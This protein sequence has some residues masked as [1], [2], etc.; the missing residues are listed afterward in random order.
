MKGIAPGRAN[1]IGEHVDYNDGYILPFAIDKVTEVNVENSSDGLIHIISEGY[2]EECFAP[3]ELKK[4]DKWTD[5]IKGVICVL[6][7]NT[8][9]KIEALTYRVISNVPIGAGLSSSA[10]VEVATAEALNGFYRL[11]MSESEIYTFAQKAENEFVGMK[12]GIMDQFISVTGR[13]NNAV[14]LDIMSMKYEYVPVD[15]DKFKFII[16]NSNVK[17]SLGDSEYNKRREECEEALEA[18]GKKSF[19]ELFPEELEESRNLLTYEQYKR[20]RHVVE[21]NRRVLDCRVALEKA[22]VVKV[23]MLLNL[24]HESLRDFYEVSCEEIDYIVERFKGFPQVL[25]GRIMGGGFGGSAIILCTGYDFL[26]R[27]KELEEEYKN[28]FGVEFDI[29]RVKPSKG[30]YFESYD[31]AGNNREN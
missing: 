18:L 1:I 9:M 5:Y 17:H 22:D 28:R 11:N 13:E 16:V 3:E 19:R 8:G 27:I 14:F 25:G 21:E 20:A 10:A 29:Y 24:T 2:G 7:E 12:C 23:G 4:T 31:V 30:A 26:D 6:S 15:E